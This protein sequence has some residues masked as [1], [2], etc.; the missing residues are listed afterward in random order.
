MLEKHCGFRIGDFY[1]GEGGVMAD[2]KGVFGMWGREDLKE[3][4]IF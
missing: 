1:D 3:M 2:K 4:P